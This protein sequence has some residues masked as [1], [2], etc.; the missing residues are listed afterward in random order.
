MLNADL[1][2]KNDASAMKAKSTKA[3]E[4]E[5]TAGFHFIAFVPIDGHVWILDGL[6]RQPRNLG[7]G[8]MFHKILST[9]MNL[10]FSAGAT[11]GEDWVGQTKPVIEAR[12]AEYE[13]EQTEFAILGLVKDPLESYSPRLASNV[14]TLV[15]VTDRL[16]ELQPDWKQFTTDIGNSEATASASALTSFSPGYDLDE[17]S[18]G[19]AA[20]IAGAKEKLRSDIIADLINYRQR[21]VAD[22]AVIRASIKEEQQSNATDAEQAAS[23][24]F[25]YVCVVQG[26][27]RALIRK[28]AVTPLL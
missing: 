4:D 25:D 3:T 8:T 28:D 1:Q 13:E 19:D 22:Q 27:L 18:L 17:K 9:A 20:L 21:L 15:A 5:S 23:W 2:L 24:R 12:M 10:C 11:D 14:K 7:K 16:N 6:E 26:L